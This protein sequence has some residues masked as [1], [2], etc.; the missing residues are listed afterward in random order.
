MVYLSHIYSLISVTLYRIAAVFEGKGGGKKGRYQGKANTLKTRSSAE[1][2]L[3]EF[4][5]MLVNES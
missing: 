2:L 4:T 5:S 1:D 3:K